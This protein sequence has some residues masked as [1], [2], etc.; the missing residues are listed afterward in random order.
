LLG[1]DAWNLW[2]QNDYWRPVF[3][4]SLALDYSL[5]GL[6]PFGFH[7]TNIIL[8]AIN[9]VLLYSLG[10]K[11][12]GRTCAVFASLLYALHPIQAHT[13]NVISTR[14]GSSCGSFCP[15]F[16]GGFLIEENKPF[17]TLD[18]ASAL[19]KRGIRCTTPSFHCRFDYSPKRKARPKASV[20]FCY[21]RSLLRDATVSRIFFFSS[22]TYLLLRC[23]HNSPYTA[24][25]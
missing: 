4:L 9:A 6:N 23:I 25:L 10:N 24:R 19:V 12:Q 5:W 13:V 8:H 1:K 14:G 15:A 11:L 20:G 18:G 7:L 3:S 16:R 2:G 21:F 22:C 17:C